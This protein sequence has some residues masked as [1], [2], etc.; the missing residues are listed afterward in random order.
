MR[1]TARLGGHD[2]HAVDAVIDIVTEEYRRVSESFVTTEKATKLSACSVKPGDLLITKVGDPPGVAAVY[3]SAQPDGI[4]TQD[5]VRLRLNR[6]IA[7]PEYLAYFLNSSMGR[8]LIAGITVAA[9]RARFS[10][11]DLKPLK[12][13]LPPISVQ[14]NFKNAI[15]SLHDTNKVQVRAQTDIDSLF[16]S[17]QSRAFSGQL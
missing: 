15:S 4:V 8:Y 1:W 13:W 17:L 12:M 6:D 5:V 11:R 10:L 3:P 14:M 7:L 2:G 9:T 16:S